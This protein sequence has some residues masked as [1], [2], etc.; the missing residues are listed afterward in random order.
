MLCAISAF[1]AGA[2]ALLLVV[3]AVL[4]LV[5]LQG[6]A[7]K[8]CNGNLNLGDANVTGDMAVCQYS[9]QGNRVDFDR[10]EYFR[11]NV[12]EQTYQKL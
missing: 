9:P 2:T 11:Q 12:R 4:L 6:C 8:F 5:L 1:Q 7:T 10:E 3:V